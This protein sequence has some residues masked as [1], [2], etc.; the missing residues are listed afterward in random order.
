MIEQAAYLHGEKSCTDTIVGLAQNYVG[1]NNV[2]LFLP[3]GQ[4]GT[5]TEGGDDA[6]SARYINTALNPIARHIFSLDDAPILIHLMEEGQKIEPIYYLPIL[7]MLLINGCKQGI[8]SGWCSVIPSFNPRDIAR[9][10]KLA[11]CDPTLVLS[12]EL[13]PLHPWIRGF[14]GTITPHETKGIDYYHI[15]GRA[16]I[17]RTD[18]DGDVEVLVDEVP[19]DAK[20][21][22]YLSSLHQMREWK[23]GIGA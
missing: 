21:S 1:S 11:I 10:T 7:C 8:G 18:K 19:Y 17:I 20:L 12:H 13:H 5:R 4:F 3:S 22:D 14:R 9:L 6:A 23:I 16:R 15:R 2:N